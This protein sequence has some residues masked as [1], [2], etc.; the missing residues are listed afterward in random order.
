MGAGEW[1]LFWREEV[2]QGVRNEYMLGVLFPIQV[3][4]TASTEMQF[5]RWL[6]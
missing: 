6:L 4:T 2:M 1:G 3:V 5:I